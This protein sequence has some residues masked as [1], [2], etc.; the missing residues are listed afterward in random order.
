MY[1]HEQVTAWP[2]R[3]TCWVALLMR[4][5]RAPRAA[6]GL[7]STGDRAPATGTRCRQW[8]PTCCPC[9]RETAANALPR[10]A[11]PGR[12]GGPARR[13]KALPDD[14]PANA[15]PADA[16]AKALPDAGLANALPDG[17][18]NT[19]LADRP[20]ALATAGAACVAADRSTPNPLAGTPNAALHS[21]RCCCTISL[22]EIGAALASTQ[23]RDGCAAQ[24]R[25]ILPIAAKA[26]ASRQHNPS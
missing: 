1:G 23:R 8:G 14:S 19:S 3:P 2:R 21:G 17:L 10:A 24:R 16:P 7:T 12:S 13:T 4:R 15:L 26:Q 9:G 22:L 11:R 20:D 6:G 25:S 5:E 18:A